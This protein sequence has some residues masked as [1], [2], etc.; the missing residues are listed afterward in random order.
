[1]K[2]S[3]TILSLFLMIAPLSAQN[4]TGAWEG[5]L[6]IQGTTL[7]I[8]FHIDKKDGMLSATMDSPKQGAFGLAMDTCFYDQDILTITAERLMLTVTAKPTGDQL[9]GTFKQGMLS[10]PLSLKRSN[11]SKEAPG[12]PQDPVP[13]YPYL[14]EDITFRNATADIQLAGTL[15][16]PKNVT[17]PTVVIMISGSGPQNRNEELMNH[18]PFL[19]W[20]DYFTRQGI[21]VLRF[22]DRGVG[23]S[24][25][26]HATATS[27]DFAEDVK[28]A[29][30][31]VKQQEA[32]RNSKV[33]LVGHSEGGLIAPIV[34]AED[35][36]AVDFI[37]L[38]AGPGVPITEL[39]YEQTSK[40]LDGL[41]AV[42]A[43]KKSFLD[44]QKAMYDLVVSSK[45]LSDE[46]MQDSMF[47]F[48][49]KR[50]N[51]ANLR[52]N[53]QMKSQ[54]AQICSP[55]WRFF[56]AYDP[57]PTLEKIKVPVLAINGDKDVQVVAE[58]NI[59]GIEAALKKGGNN[60]LTTRIFPGLNH[61][62][63]TAKT[64][65]PDEY[66]QIEETVNPEVLE[67]VTEWIKKMK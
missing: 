35:P 58:Q 64:G 18:R 60:Q 8:V 33:G 44:Q 53:P 42:E 39:M 67:Y 49:E 34:A 40:A 25:G 21:A 52:D 36:K 15:T 56:L 6:D 27:E 5:T 50:N 63:Q 54:V 48:F 37:V 41:G 24:G 55:W 43:R 11:A 12:R 30:A 4:L 23:Q 62:F 7:P 51:G 32:F 66:A 26:D 22:D 31:Y 20:A 10:I 19:V 13:P 59:P 14:S 65:Q 45:D 38:L 3:I 2:S 1:M 29:V 16:R 46:V 61:L 17:A 28:A 47:A 9:E 57:T